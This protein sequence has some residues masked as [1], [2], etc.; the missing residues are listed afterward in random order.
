MR[1]SDELALAAHERSDL[2]YALLLKDAGCTANSAHMAALFGADD[3]VAKRTS[4]F[5]D[6]SRPLAR[7]KIERGTDDRALHTRVVLNLEATPSK[8]DVPSII[9][10]NHKVD[11]SSSHESVKPIPRTRFRKSIEAQ[12]RRRVS[13]SPRAVLRGDCR[14]ASQA[15]IFKPGGPG[16]GNELA[17]L[18]SWRA[19]AHDLPALWLHDPRRG[20]LPDERRP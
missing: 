18:S 15:L 11:R 20:P 3:Q 7:P 10:A 14:I 17:G 12:A 4:K 1:L 13:P 5:V 9:H 6:W 19:T 2:F 8:H 16:W